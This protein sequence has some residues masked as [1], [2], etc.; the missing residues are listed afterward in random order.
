MKN[1]KTTLLA[2]F[3]AAGTLTATAQNVNKEVK[4]AESK[5]NWKAYKVT[6]S[7]E[8]DVKLQSGTLVFNGDKLVGG[9]FIVD[10]TTINT[11][12]MSGEYKDKLDGH[13]KSDDF[14]GVEKYTT[15][16]LVFKS[17]GA[18][19][20]NAYS[21]TADL[22]IKGK[23][24]PVKFD[25]AVY[26]SKANATLK[27]DRAKYDIKYGSGSFFDGLGDKTIYDEFDLVV[28]LQF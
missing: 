17:I 25:I 4:A 9:T 19:S 21:V 14:F 10:M 5:V 3:V 2:L 26:G 28:D 24:L 11:T 20:K 15:S 13:L 16:K 18:K 7:H 1:V 8:G 23:T 6:G 12:D 27:I 22:T